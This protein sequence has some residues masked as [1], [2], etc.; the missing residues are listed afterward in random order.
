MEDPRDKAIFGLIYLYG[1]RVSE[2]TILK[3]EDVDLKRKRIFI[4]RVKGGAGGE[5]P[6]FR[7]T[8]K[9]LRKYLAVRQEKGDGLFTGRQGT[10]SR[11]RIHQ[12]FK[13]YAQR[14]GLDPK[15]TVHS[16]RHSI[17]THLLE[18]GM[19]IEF[20]KDHLGHRDIRNRTSDSKCEKMV[21]KQR[22]DDAKEQLET[23]CACHFTAI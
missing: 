1:L 11:K 15:S 8:E 4:R 5:R 12:L 23:I 3:L 21:A 17:A 22:A 10:L 7:S 9:L 2:A 20:I 14:A 19:G 13:G 6:I 16:L 18:T